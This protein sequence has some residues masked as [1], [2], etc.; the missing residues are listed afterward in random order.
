MLNKFL[1]LGKEVAQKM[2]EASKMRCEKMDT[3]NHELKK[4]KNCCTNF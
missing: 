4:L 3:S 2:A 1:P